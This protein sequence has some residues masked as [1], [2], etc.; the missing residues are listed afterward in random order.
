MSRS[1]SSSRSARWIP[2]QRDSKRQGRQ[3]KKPKSWRSNK[4]ML[5]LLL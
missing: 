1:A 5:K 3:R 2:F 4:L